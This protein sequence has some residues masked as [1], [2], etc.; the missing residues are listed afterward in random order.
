M[1]QKQRWGVIDLGSNTVRLC[2]Y[3][4]SG[5]EKY[6]RIATSKFAVGLASYVGED[7]VLDA[8]GVKAANRA[9][10]KLSEMSKLMGC[11][12]TFAFVTGAARNCVNSA[13][14]IAAIEEA[15]GQKLEVLPGKDEARLSLMGSLETVKVD[16]GL[17]F[18]IGGGSTE[19]MTMEKGKYLL[20]DSL[21]M[22][23]LSSWSRFVSSILPED[24][25]LDAVRDAIRI[26]I[27][28][29][30]VDVSKHDRV[31][32]IGGSMRLALKVSHELR[33]DE[34][35]DRVV[36]MDDFERIFG[37]LHTDSIKLSGMLL[38]MNPARVHTFLPGCVIAREI[39]LKAGC[40]KITVAKSGLREGYLM[41]KM[42]DFA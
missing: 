40:D 19:L 33:E 11:D 27:D 30:E 3:D 34:S 39:M 24:E 21:P 25:E 8:R 26:L 13:E 2:V 1:A 5:P 18:D 6:K 42:A 15:S 32:G 20:G 29:C 9:V 37:L 41:A 4:I 17:F 38:Q 16:S 23:S 14:V 12:T 22:G 31:F 35:D 10:R 28:S 7:G 36:T